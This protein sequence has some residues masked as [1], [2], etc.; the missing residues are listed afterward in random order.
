[1]RRGVPIPDAV[2]EEGYFDQPH[3]TRSLRRWVG[4]TPARISAAGKSA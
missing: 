1:L 2:H 4:L 3:M